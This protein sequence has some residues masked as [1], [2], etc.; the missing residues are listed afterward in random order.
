MAA[1]E[2]VP[3]IVEQRLFRQFGQHAQIG[4]FP[5]LK[6][7]VLGPLHKELRLDR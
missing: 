1:V 5:I 6:S 2:A 7:L 3:E 4:I